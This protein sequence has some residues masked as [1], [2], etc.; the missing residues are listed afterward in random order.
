M[1]FADF[2]TF[3]PWTNLAIFAVA[4]VFVWIAGTRLAACADAIGARTRLSRAFLGMILLGVATSLPEVATT[5]TGALIGNAQLVAGNL[6]GGVAL[7][8]A[9]LAIID[10]IAVRGALTWFTPQPVL[11]FQGVMLL[12]LLGLALAGAA[13]GDPIVIAGIGLTPILLATGYVLTVRY[14]RSGDHLPRWRAN[15]E[16]EPPHVEDRH[17]PFAGTSNPALYANCAV[18]GAVILAAGWGLAQTGDALAEQTGLGS[19]FVGVALV[20]GSTS[21]PELSTG[22]GAVRQGNHTMAVSNILGTNCLEVA[23]FFLADL[24]YRGGP[25]LAATDQSARFAGALGLVVTSIYVLGLLQR[26]N[27]TV[28]N[29]GLDSIGVLTAYVIGLVTLYGLR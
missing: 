18:S 29:M 9:V 4:A 5:V 19:S 24:V 21:L 8:I 11:L 15:E 23:L 2:R 13:A 28:M 22:L 3:S 7:Q 10:A 6:F 1:R 25:I 14:S 12:L 26:R 16:P 17:E 20:A 27:R